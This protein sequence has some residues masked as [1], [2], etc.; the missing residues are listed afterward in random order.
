VAKNNNLPLRS[1]KRKKF[2]GLLEIVDQ[3]TGE[4]ISSAAKFKTD[5]VKTIFAT[6]YLNDEKVYE[7]VS[8]L[9]NPGKVLAFILKDYNDRSGM[10]YFSTHTKALMAKELNLSVNTIRSIVREFAN[11]KTIVHIGGPEYMVN[12]RLFYKGAQE[13]YDTQ[14]KIFD[15][16]HKIAL[17]KEAQV[18]IDA[19]TA[20]V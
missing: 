14:V 11:K 4:V 1:A 7:F 9:G 12:P 17:F 18:N 5:K 19:K 3:Q 13:H 20:N 10:F 15:D 2:V 6:M 8:G 16:Y